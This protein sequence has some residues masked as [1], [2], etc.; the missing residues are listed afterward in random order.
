MAHLSIE[1][2]RAFFCAAYMSSP[3]HIELVLS[4]KV[5]AV[6]AGV[7]S[8]LSWFCVL[9]HSSSSFLRMCCREVLSLSA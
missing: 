3:C 8:P 7:V 1:T 9:A 6:P 2:D 5:S 4:E